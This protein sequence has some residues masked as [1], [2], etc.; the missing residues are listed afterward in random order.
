MVA[1]YTEFGEVLWKR[2]MQV[3]VFCDHD[4]IWYRGVFCAFQKEK[5]L[6]HIYE[7]KPL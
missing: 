1:N 2:G 4:N 5:V 7:K 6:I 3:H